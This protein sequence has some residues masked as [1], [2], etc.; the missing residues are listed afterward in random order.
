MMERHF[1][2]AFTLFYPFCLL[3]KHPALAFPVGLPRQKFDKI[4]RTWSPAEMETTSAV[5]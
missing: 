1:S 2:A 5:A 4:E 3:L